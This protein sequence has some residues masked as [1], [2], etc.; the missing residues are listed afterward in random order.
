[1]NYQRTFE[2]LEA[3]ASKFWP[4]ELS[5]RE[6][7]LSI[8]PLLLETQDQF[9]GFLTVPSTDIE[10]I[11]GVL[12]NTTFSG[13]LFLKHL[14]ILADFGGELLQRVSREFTTLFPDGILYYEHQGNSHSYHFKALPKQKLTNT[15]LHIDGKRL[16][17]KHDLDDLKKDAIA[18]MLFGRSHNDSLAEPSSILAKCEI[19][20][21]VGKP[22]ELAL[23]IKQRYIWVR[24]ITGGAKYNNLVV[25]K[26]SRDWVHSVKPKES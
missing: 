2:E 7:E 4:T 22:D 14:S 23:F 25:P 16:S 17:E 3:V 20:D 5:V 19:G 24:R 6:A 15:R 10:G 13:N 9:V 26:S 18:L 21:F 11:F 12:E 8:V 1:M